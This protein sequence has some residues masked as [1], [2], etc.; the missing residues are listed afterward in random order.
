[1]WQSIKVILTTFYAML[2]LEIVCNDKTNFA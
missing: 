1:G 2:S